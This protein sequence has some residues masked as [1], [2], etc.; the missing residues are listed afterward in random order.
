VTNAHPCATNVLELGSADLTGVSTFLGVYSSILC[1]NS[2]IITEFLKKERDVNVRSANG[3][4]NVGRDGSS[5]V[6][7][8]DK[9]FC[10]RDCSVA[11]PVTTNEIGAFSIGGRFAC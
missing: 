6:E 11:F 8:L 4:L 3:N 7:N 2:N 5:F 10:R 1:C 9:L